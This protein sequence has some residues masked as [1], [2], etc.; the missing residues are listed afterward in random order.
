[1]RDRGVGGWV[2]ELHNAEMSQLLKC[3]YAYKYIIM[4]QFIFALTVILY[5]FTIKYFTIVH[6]V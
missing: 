6:I 5:E 3:A 2:V 1:M 4:S